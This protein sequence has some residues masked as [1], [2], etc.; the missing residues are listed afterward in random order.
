MA[1]YAADGDRVQSVSERFG[2]PDQID[3]IAAMSFGR[4]RSP[5]LHDYRYR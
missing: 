3:L 1:E 4:P 5:N 2:L